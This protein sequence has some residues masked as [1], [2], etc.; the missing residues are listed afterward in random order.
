MHDCN[1]FLWVLAVLP[2]NRRRYL[3]KLQQQQLLLG[4]GFTPMQGS[5][6][7]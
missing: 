2:A 1:A 7:D 3:C 6:N 5:M 4:L